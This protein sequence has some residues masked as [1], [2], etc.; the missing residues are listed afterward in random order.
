MHNRMKQTKPALIQA[1]LDVLTTKRQKPTWFDP[2]CQDR[3]RPNVYRR[4]STDQIERIMGEV[5]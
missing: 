1:C 3:L 5:R 4:R 2:H